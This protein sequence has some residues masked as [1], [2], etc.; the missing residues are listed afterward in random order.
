MSDQLTNKAIET[1]CNEILKAVE[2]KTKSI[3]SQMIKKSKSNNSDS[4]Q[5]NL[6]PSQMEAKEMAIMTADEFY[7]LTPEK[8]KELYQSGI[9]LI[10][11]DE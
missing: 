7:I 6:Q 1:L 8:A 3:C 5:G 11:V 10:I 4:T 9:R 2:V